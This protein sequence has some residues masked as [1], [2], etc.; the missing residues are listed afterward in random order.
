[1]L[2][3]VKYYILHNF[4]TCILLQGD[5]AKDCKSNQLKKYGP[6]RPPLAA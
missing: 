4:K 6:L 5:L 3:V 2:E 1:M